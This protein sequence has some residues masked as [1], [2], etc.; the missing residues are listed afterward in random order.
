MTTANE[1]IAALNQRRLL[2]TGRDDPP[3]A[4][5]PGWQHWF[6]GLGRKDAAS[7][8]AAPTALVDVFVQRPLRAIPA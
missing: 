3:T 8:H 1:V 5:P 7:A 2:K 4:T 6:D